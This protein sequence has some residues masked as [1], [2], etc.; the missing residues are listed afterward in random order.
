MDA[1]AYKVSYRFDIHLGM[2]G[3]YSFSFNQPAL[4]RKRRRMERETIIRDLQKCGGQK[5]K[6]N[7]PFLSGSFFVLLYKNK[8]INF[9]ILLKQK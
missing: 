1:F 8:I 3:N 7:P 2:G 5:K 4:C 9:K 6:K